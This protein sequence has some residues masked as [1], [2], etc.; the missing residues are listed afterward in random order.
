MHWGYLSVPAQ[1]LGRGEG[2]TPE[3][4]H[5][6]PATQDEIAQEQNKCRKEQQRAKFHLILESENSPGLILR[7]QRG[8]MWDDLGKSR[9]SRPPIEDT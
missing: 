2:L 7:D 9:F 6:Q 3:R 1:G 4:A 5:G 8:R